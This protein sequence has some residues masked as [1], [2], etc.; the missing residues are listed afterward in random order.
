[1]LALSVVLNIIESFIPI[2]NIPGLKIGLANS[3]VLFVLYCYGFKEAF[4]TSIF[5][6]IIVGLL[7]TGL[8]SITFM[9][10]LGGSI[11]SIITMYLFKKIKVLSIIGVSIIGAIAHSIGQIIM[12]MLI[13]KN[14]NLIYYLPY[15]L[16]FAIPSGILIGI[17]SKNILKY[18][19]K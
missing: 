9:F 2:S 18:Y 14:Y 1:M 5:R 3:I 17:I 4:Y 6:V 16:L 19:K 8:F 13:L 10:S 11:L 15:L 7:R 12:A